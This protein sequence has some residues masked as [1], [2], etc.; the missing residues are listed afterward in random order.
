MTRAP[1]PKDTAVGSDGSVRR[2]N[3]STTMPRRPSSRPSALTY[4]CIPPESR[5]PGRASG[6]PWTLSIAILNVATRFPR[7]DRS[8]HL[9]AKSENRHVP[10]AQ[11]ILVRLVSL[12]KVEQPPPFFNRVTQT[13]RF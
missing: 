12:E 5:V 4:I 10:R 6:H 8:F 2:V 3:T 1:G 11:I 7:P 9:H 13:E